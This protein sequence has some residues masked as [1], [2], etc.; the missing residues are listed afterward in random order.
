M[1]ECGSAAVVR[2]ARAAEHRT[3]R[4]HDDRGARA[5]AAL[6]PGVLEVEGR[7]RLHGSRR[8]SSSRRTSRSAQCRRHRRHTTR[9]SSTR[10]SRTERLR[11]AWA[12]TFPLRPR[13]RIVVSDG[14]QQLSKLCFNAATARAQNACTAAASTPPSA[15]E[16]SERGASEGD[17]SRAAPSVPPLSSCARLASAASPPRTTASPSAAASRSSTAAL[18]SSPPPH[19]SGA[20]DATATRDARTSVA[21][22]RERSSD[23]LLGRRLR[24]EPNARR[25]ARRATL[26]IEVAR[27]RVPCSSSRCSRRL[28]WQ[29]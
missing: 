5:D 3:H 27:C 2:V 21:T 26:S 8:V 13:R 7:R 6:D 10:T 17:A 28:R 29:P 1:A 18:R 20:S 14:A 25:G 9:R 22:R 15:D 24:D 12:C 11:R 16:V 19:A 4:R 23:P